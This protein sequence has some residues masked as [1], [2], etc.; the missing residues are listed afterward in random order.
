[1]AEQKYNDDREAKKAE[2]VLPDG[3]EGSERRAYPRIALSTEVKFSVVKEAQPAHDKE[4]EDL[5]NLG[6]ENL[7]K[8]KAVATETVNLS[9]AGLL[10]NTDRDIAPGST[11]HITLHVPLPG[12]S[13]TCS[14]LAEIIRSD[15]NP[16]GTFA[17]AVKFL[18][19]VHH[20]LSK[21]K[22]AALHDLLNLEGPQ[23]KLD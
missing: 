11:I 15:K 18:K 4:H 13:C 7:E 8:G 6:A 16:D 9:S 19:V 10:M 5:L 21:Y 20:N 2:L 3:K 17:T 12:I 23:I 1:M 22:Y 14:M